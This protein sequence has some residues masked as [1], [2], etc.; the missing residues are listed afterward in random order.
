MSGILDSLSSLVDKAKDK[1]NESLVNDKK[2][3]NLQS[4][5]RKQL[6]QLKKTKEDSYNNN[7]IDPSVNEGK[8]IIADKKDN[9]HELMKNITWAR[10]QLGKEILEFFI[11]YDERNVSSDGKLYK[12]RLEEEF[13]EDKDLSLEYNNNAYVEQENIYVENNLGIDK[14]KDIDPNKSIGDLI[15]EWMKC[16]TFMSSSI[17]GFDG[18]KIDF[19]SIGFDV[20]SAI[21]YLIR[22]YSTTKSSG[23]CARAVRES[24]V[25]GGLDTS[26]NPI[27]AIE[28]VRFLPK[29][30]FKLIRYVKYDNNYSTYMTGMAVPGDIAVMANPKGGAGHICMYCGGKDKRWN[31]DFKQNRAWVYGGQCGLLYIYR[32]AGM[33]K[34]IV[35]G[36]IKIPQA[37][38]SG[39]KNGVIITKWLSQRL[40][41]SPIN[42]IGFAGCWMQE[43]QCNPSLYNKAEKSGKFKG[44]S[45]NGAG[46]GAGI[47]QWSN[48]RKFNVMRMMK[49]SQPIETWPLEMQLNAAVKELRTPFIN[50]LKNCNSIEQS[51]DL[52]LRGYEN[53][54]GGSGPLASV[55]QINKYTWD[56]GYA[57]AMAKRVGYAKQVWAALS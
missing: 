46:Y 13:D 6:E 41:L 30:G 43:S 53:G 10:N 35:S 12:N 7:G 26:G 28:Y 15:L 27:N 16:G 25:A 44:S 17:Y 34:A 37:G 19:S 22:N 8:W 56:G 9:T 23:V 31:S 42:V 1:L 55:A 4:N 2:P 32:F 11:E 57:G 18:M 50:K 20:D 33:E 38:G 24:L 3:S 36:N 52:V 21:N 51:V 5:S 49:T 48:Q 39:I 54:G 40:N 47:A 14:R 29:L 45:A